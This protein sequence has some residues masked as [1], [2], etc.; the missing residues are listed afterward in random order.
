MQEVEEKEWKQLGDK[1][2]EKL[3]AVNINWKQLGIVRNGEILPLNKIVALQKCP[4]VFPQEKQNKTKKQDEKLFRRDSD[5][6]LTWKT[7]TWSSSN[8]ADLS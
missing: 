4:V 8:D 5:C 6:A 7:W 2:K 3:L 1:R